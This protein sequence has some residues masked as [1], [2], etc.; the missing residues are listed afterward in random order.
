MRAGACLDKVLPEALAEL[1]RLGLD[2]R[3]GGVSAAMPMYGSNANKKDGLPGGMGDLGF[4]LFDLISG[5]R[6]AC[7]AGRDRWGSC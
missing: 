5:K 4:N 1:A 7:K 2:L 3:G 6:R